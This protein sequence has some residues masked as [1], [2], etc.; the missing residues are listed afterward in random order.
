MPATI[1][2]RS[3]K[4]LQDIDARFASG[5]YAREDLAQLERLNAELEQLAYDPGAHMRHCE[6][7]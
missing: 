2:P 1:A 3:C 5:A 7:S 6:K 4:S